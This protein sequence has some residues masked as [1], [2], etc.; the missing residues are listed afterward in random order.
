MLEFLDDKEHDKF[1]GLFDFYKFL[2]SDKTNVLV[3]LMED[4]ENKFT[5][6]THEISGITITAET[7]QNIEIGRKVESQVFGIPYKMGNLTSNEIVLD[8]NG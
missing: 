2:Y 4:P 3:P 5:I 7:H 1:R 8:R 6:K